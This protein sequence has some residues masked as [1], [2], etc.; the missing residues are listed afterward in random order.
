MKHPTFISQSN[1]IDEM[2]SNAFGIKDGRQ[3][4]ERYLNK[5]KE[6]I[7]DSKNN[8]QAICIKDSSHPAYGD[9]PLYLTY[10]MALFSV[11][12]KCSM[13]KSQG[14]STQFHEF[15]VCLWLE[16]L[17]KTGMHNNTFTMSNLVMRLQ[18]F[19]DL[20]VY[21]HRLGDGAKIAAGGALNTN[22]ASLT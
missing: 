9:Q 7:P 3:H 4:Y 15:A 6:T 20:V 19:R 12:Q 14:N 18:Q 21:D 1:F 8:L 17:L 13:V 11:V 2:G 5:F 22:T 10:E 16:F